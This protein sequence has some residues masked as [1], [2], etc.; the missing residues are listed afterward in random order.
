MGRFALRKNQRFREVGTV[1]YQDGDADPILSQTHAQLLQVH[2]QLF[3]L[4]LEDDH[5]GN[6]DG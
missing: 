6:R 3:V 2:K 5:H 1:L 4:S